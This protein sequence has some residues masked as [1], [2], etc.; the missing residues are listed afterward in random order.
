LIEIMNKINYKE[1][2]LVIEDIDAMI[3]IVK[4]RQEIKQETKTYE[5]Y[6]NELNKKKLTVEEWALENNKDKINKITLS[7]L[8]NVIDGVFTCHG[9]ILI[10]TT[11]HPEVL[12]SALIRP[13]RIDCKF[14][15]SNCNKRQIGELYEVFFNK[16]VNIEQLNN[17]K[18]IDY[19]PAQITS[20]F[21]RYRNT[22]EIA[23]EHLDNEYNPIDSNIK[24]IDC[25]GNMNIPTEYSIKLKNI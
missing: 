13:G 15:F 18:N 7:G 22:P 19:S 1:T 23:L 6:T 25:N 5:E 9:R 21:L 17:I 4:T 24:I 11:N 12:D 20:I 14:L 10:M 8:L 16:S 3:N 2:I